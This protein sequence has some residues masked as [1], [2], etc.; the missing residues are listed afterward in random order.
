[1]SAIQNHK[2]LWCKKRQCDAKDVQ[3][4]PRPPAKS[5]LQIFICS[6]SVLEVNIIL[7]LLIFNDAIIAL[8]E[9]YVSI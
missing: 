3:A 8:F 4:K 9:V 7:D 1:M 2:A 6:C 5:K